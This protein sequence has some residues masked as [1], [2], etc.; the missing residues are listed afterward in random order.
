MEQEELDGDT[1]SEIGGR[2]VSEG[3]ALV[4]DVLG[5]FGKLF[6]GA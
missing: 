2:E 1:V 4:V 6:G 3:L 5:S